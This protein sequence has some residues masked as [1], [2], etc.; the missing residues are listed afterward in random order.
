MAAYEIAMRRSVLKKD[1]RRMPKADVRRI[2]V[3]IRS[4]ANDPR[5]P[6]VQKLSGGEKYR[7]RQGDYRII[8]SIQDDARSIW[9]AKVAPASGGNRQ[10]PSPR[11]RPTAR[12]RA[13]SALHAGCPG[14]R[15]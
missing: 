2:V 10:G 9:I 8:Y 12:P 4:L 13:R 3:A 14:H 6:G 11:Q 1:L 5:P 15:V 7:I